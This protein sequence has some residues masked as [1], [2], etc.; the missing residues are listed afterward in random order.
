MSQYVTFINQAEKQ[1]LLTIQLAKEPIERAL[2]F[3]RTKHGA[4]KIVKH[5]HAANIGCAAIHGNKSQPQRTLALQAFRKGD[6]KILIATDIAARGIDVSGVSHVFN[7]DMPNVPEQYVHRIGRTARAGAEGIAISYVCGEEKGWLKQIERLTGVRLDQVPL[8]ADFD[9]QKAQ[10]PK[11]VR[12]E[13]E[14]QG[15]R[16]DG[17]GRGGQPE[18]KRQFHPRKPGGVGVHKAAVRRTGSR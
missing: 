15:R 3:S 12:T 18:A 6:I 11:P 17:G 7:F 16:P 5:L 2:V 14:R 13:P 1:A 8:P 4:D 9:A 10:L